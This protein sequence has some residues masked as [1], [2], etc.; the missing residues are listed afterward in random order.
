MDWQVFAERI[1]AMAHDLLNQSSVDETLGRI[2]GSA[3]ELVAGCDAAGIL[4]LSGTQSV[5][6][7][8]SETLVA[9]LDQLQRR[10]GQ[11][12]SFD[13]ARRSSKER[14]FRIADFIE[15]E[16]RWSGFVPEALKRGVGSMMGFLLFTEEED[17]GALNFYSRRAGAFTEESERAGVLLASHAA[18]A[19]SAARTH[20]Q[21][22]QAVATRHQIGQAMGILMSR[23]NIPENEAFNRL[24]GYSQNNN[25]KLR[26]VA[27][28]VCEQGAL[29]SS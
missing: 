7:A 13:A 14:V 3:T 10:L 5:S 12:P 18:V 2:T 23:H 4:V 15:V 6:L 21:L 20:A 11:G 19:L 9:E 24:R 27:L 16:P 26:D 17:F 29:P 25:V 28:L 8:P 1:G 22:E